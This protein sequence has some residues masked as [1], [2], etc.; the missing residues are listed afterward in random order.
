[1]IASPLDYLSTVAL[2]AGAHPP[3]G[4]VC[5]MEALA[6]ALGCPHSDC[7]PCT[8]APLAAAF[9]A[10]NDWSGWRN[11]E[12]RTAFL[13]PYMMRLGRLALDGRHAPA[14]AYAYAAADV[15]CRLIAPMALD[16]AGV[17]KAAAT[18]L[19]LAPVVGGVTARAAAT[20]AT[21]TATAAAAYAATATAAYAAY[22]A[23]AATY[24]D[25]DAATVATATAATAYAADAA[26]YAAA[27]DAA[28]YAAAA[29]PLLDRLLDVCEAGCWPL[30]DNSERAE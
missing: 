7:P 13:R 11:D 24:A 6:L 25:A 30:P 28:T 9:R 22:A 21:A 26:T 29:K 20:A 3:G 8:D 10:V 15:A 23:D 17:G 4:A 2:T 1:M 18:L 19:G 27:A 12:A 16:A 5:A 14:T